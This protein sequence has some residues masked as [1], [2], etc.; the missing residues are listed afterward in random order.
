MLPFYVA[1][2]LLQ[3]GRY[4]PIVLRPQDRVSDCC[5]ESVSLVTVGADLVLYQMS[6]VVVVHI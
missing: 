2:C 1:R 4:M 5:M 3:W 6:S